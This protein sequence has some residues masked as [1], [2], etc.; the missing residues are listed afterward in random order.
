[1][2]DGSLE[3]WR[4][5]GYGILALLF[6]CDIITTTIDRMCGHHELNPIMIPYVANPLVHFIVKFIALSII[7]GLIES[8]SL[9][10]KK[11]GRYSGFVQLIFFTAVLLFNIYYA[12]GVIANIGVLLGSP[13]LV[14]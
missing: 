5:W 8:C 11:L 4:R 12:Y 10:L 13:H 2:A 14:S 9:V 7:V 3:R 6:V 1:M